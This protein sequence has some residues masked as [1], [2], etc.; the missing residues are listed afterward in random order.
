MRKIY[1]TVVFEKESSLFSEEKV[2]S[3]K[4][5]EIVDCDKNGRPKET[6]K[7]LAEL[8]K[9]IVISGQIEMLIKSITRQD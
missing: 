4:T 3:V 2:V 8:G 1:Y 5:Y 7:I 6:S 9:M